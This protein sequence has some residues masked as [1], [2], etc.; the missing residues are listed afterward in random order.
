[1]KKYININH[2]KILIC[3]LGVVIMQSAQ[4][5][6]PELLDYKMQRLASDKQDHLCELYKNRVVLVV[7]TAS[8]CGFAKQFE[9]LETLFKTYKN[10]GLSVIGF[11]SEDFRQEFKNEEQ[12]LDFCRLTYSIEF[13]MYASLSV[14]K[15]KAHPFFKGLA[16]AA[17]GNYPRWNFYKYIIG[18]D[19]SLVDYYNSFAN[20]TSAKIID[21]IETSLQK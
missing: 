2:K 15:G 9:G 20:P 6:C 16:T 19:G 14:R 18:R 3:V 17:G 4:A 13:P 11:P 10:E 21:S 12:T 1:M 5:N 8:K 7:N